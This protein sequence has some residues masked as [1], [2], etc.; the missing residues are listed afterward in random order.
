MKKVIG[1]VSI[2]LCAAMLFAGGSSEAPAAAEK[3]SAPA[4]G[5][6]EIT[7]LSNS[8][9]PYDTAIPAI[10]AE[11][12][13]QNP[14]IKVNIEMLPTKN[15]LEVVEVRLGSGEKVPD[16][17]FVDAP[18][19]TAYS[20]KQYLEPLAKYFT[21]EELMRFIRHLPDFRTWMRQ[22]GEKAYPV[23]KKGKPDFHYSPAAAQWVS[24]RSWEPRRFF[25][26]MGRSAAALVLVSEG[27]QAKKLYRDMP[28]PS[29]A[30]C[31]LVQKHMGELLK[32][33]N[34][35]VQEAGKEQRT[36]K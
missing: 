1:I 3:A 17:L 16:V 12:E 22:Q 24:F 4:S 2:M 34:D 14:D 31:E 29:K 25:C 6:V 18:M 36:G 26:I 28:K 27:E 21:E 13:K 23:V 9:K 32:A 30:E 5:P 33:G 8:V 10:I 15:L 7:L 11:F 20:V 19:V 35:V